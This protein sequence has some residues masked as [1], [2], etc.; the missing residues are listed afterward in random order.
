[1][2]IR[3]KDTGIGIPEDQSESIFELFTQVESEETRQQSGLGIGL[4]LA[5]QLTE[6]HDGSIT[7]HSR[8][9][10]RGSEFVVTLPLAK[11]REV[12]GHPPEERPTGKSTPTFRI[13]VVEDNED[14]AETLALALRMGGHE[15]KTA[16]HGREGLKLA[17]GFRP[18]AAIVDIGLP[19]ISGY[20]V[21]RQLRAQFPDILLIAHTGWDQPE[22]CKRSEEAGFDHHIVKPANIQKMIGLMKR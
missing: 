17:S 14:A 2:L 22:D 11:H 12:A 20:E 18:E 8:G 21:G 5:R 1:M 16:L 3:V 4:S 7:L 9:K 10:G 13:L 15:V 6:L 19:D